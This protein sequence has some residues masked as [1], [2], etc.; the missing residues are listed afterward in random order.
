[1][2]HDQFNEKEI[3]EIRNNNQIKEIV[4]PECH[5]FDQDNVPPLDRYLTPI[6]PTTEGL[7]QS[8]I[9]NFVKTSCLFIRSEKIFF[10]EILPKKILEK[11]N[12]VDINSALLN[13]HE[14]KK[15]RAHR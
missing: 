11:Y 6:Y 3:N 9:R 8:S 15:N 12:L 5:F 2:V 14:P 4:H 10:P 13:I 1:M 7:Y